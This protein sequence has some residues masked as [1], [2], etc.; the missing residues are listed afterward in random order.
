MLSG[1]NEMRAN[2]LC[3]HMSIGL[4]NGENVSN[5][6][7]RIL[8]HAIEIW[9]RSLSQWEE[10]PLGISLTEW[11]FLYSE[12]HEWHKKRKKK[13]CCASAVYTKK[14]KGHIWGKKEKE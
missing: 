3:T 1:R 14:S 7:A 5:H 13:V 9:E 6:T 2:R 11:G 10:K 8:F 12:K 4:N